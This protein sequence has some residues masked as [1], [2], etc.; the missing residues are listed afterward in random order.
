MGRGYEK[1][2]RADESVETEEDWYANLLWI[3]RRKCVLFA[4]VGMHFPLLVLDVWVAE[5]RDPGTLLR[6][7]LRATLL[8]IG[9][10]PGQ[11]AEELLR[12]GRLELGR[13]TNRRVLGSMNDYAYQAQAYAESCSGVVEADSA[14]ISA[15]IAES[16]MSA[17][18][19]KSPLGLMC[20]R[21]GIPDRNRLDWLKR[22]T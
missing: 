3:E 2:V 10:S 22:V 8:R 1:S 15:Q 17:I 5:L 7:A 9:A 14:S 21:L 4:S 20:E 19:Y 11:V 12:L 18:G 6:E 13:S 16:P